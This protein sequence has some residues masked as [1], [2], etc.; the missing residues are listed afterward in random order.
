MV[1][2]DCCLIKNGTIIHSRNLDFEEPSIMRKVVYRAIFKKN[3]L[4]SFDAVMF[5]G[6]VGIYTGMKKGSFSVSEN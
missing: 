1:H 2:F 6:T 3:G 5:A 4:Y